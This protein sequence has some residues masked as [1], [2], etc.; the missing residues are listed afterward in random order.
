MCQSYRKPCACGQRTSEIFFGNMVLDQAAVAAVYCPECSLTVEVDPSTM[1][2][3]NGWI[4]E[5][6]A[7]VLR[8][9]APR[10]GM[11][12]A[13][14]TADEAFD[15]GFAT[16]VGMGPEDNI[17]R[18]LEREEIARRTA[19]NPRAQFEELKKWAVEREV[20]LAGE[21]WRKARPAARPAA[22]R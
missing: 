14:V 5:L 18:G 21:G 2:S 9:Y 7:D 11:E 10:M 20:R 15:G 6:D 13:S 8:A 22:L 17:Q 3:D 1:V 4:L 16:W 12:P 19:G